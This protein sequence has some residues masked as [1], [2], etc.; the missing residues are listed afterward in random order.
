MVDDALY[1]PLQYRFSVPFQ[2]VIACSMSVYKSDK[3][4]TLAAITLNTKVKMKVEKNTPLRSR[5]YLMN[6]EQ[7]SL[8]LDQQ[9]CGGSFS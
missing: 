6:P 5:R 9:V 8:N 1:F 2:N 4:K 7:F 3:A